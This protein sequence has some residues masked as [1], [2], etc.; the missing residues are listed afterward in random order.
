MARFDKF[1]IGN[2]NDSHEQWMNEIDWYTGTEAG[3]FGEFALEF[4]DGMHLVMCSNW[5]YFTDS[6]MMFVRF[7]WKLDKALN[8][9]DFVCFPV[10]DG[11]PRLCFAP[12][13]APIACYLT[14]NEML[15]HS[16]GLTDYTKYKV[17]YLS[18][19]LEFM[20]A[21]ERYLDAYSQSDVDHVRLFGDYPGKDR[22]MQAYRERQTTKV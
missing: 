19:L 16:H 15:R 13:G 8:E 7:L 12:Q 1:H 22:L 21:V 17:T 5:A 11:V 4:G 20:Q 14:E 10:I 6:A 9:R 2:F 3:N 18:T